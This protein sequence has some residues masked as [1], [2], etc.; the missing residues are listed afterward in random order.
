LTFILVASGIFLTVNF[1]FAGVIYGI[2]VNYPYCIGGV[3]FAE[4]RF[5]DAFLLSWNSFSSVVS[6]MPLL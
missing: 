5:V 2:G 3:D 4:D 1:L 6:A